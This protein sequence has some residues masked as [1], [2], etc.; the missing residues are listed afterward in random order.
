MSRR[1]EFVEQMKAQLQKAQQTPVQKPPTML[2]MIKAQTETA[3]QGF[4]GAQTENTRTSRRRTA[5][6]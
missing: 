3:R 5:K 1:D 2:D 6:S 4:I